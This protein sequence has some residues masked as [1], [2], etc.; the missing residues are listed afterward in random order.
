MGRSVGCAAPSPRRMQLATPLRSRF[1]VGKH[2]NAYGVP[3]VS[4]YPKIDKEPKSGANR[5]SGHPP[6]RIQH[7]GNCN[8]YRSRTE[9]TTFC[10]GIYKGSRR[11]EENQLYPKGDWGII[12]TAPE[13]AQTSRFCHSIRSTRCILVLRRLRHVFVVLVL[14][15]SV[16]RLWR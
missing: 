1:L 10:G 7:L 15:T 2:T 14:V 6:S 16:D 5:Q 11:R 3:K 4:R 8:F 9:R 13:E 12:L